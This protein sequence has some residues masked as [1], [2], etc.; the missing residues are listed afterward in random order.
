ML[1]LLMGEIYYYY[2]WGSDD[3]VMIHL[4]NFMNIGKGVET[5]F[6]LVDVRLV[7]LLEGPII[8]FSLMALDGMICVSSCMTIISSI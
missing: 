8:Y 6:L 3:C 7:L 4:P 2:V 5:I 1:V